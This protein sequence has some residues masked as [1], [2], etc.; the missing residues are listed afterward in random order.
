MKLNAEKYEPRHQNDASIFC[1]LRNPEM[2]SR[3]WGD[4]KDVVVTEVR[5]NRTFLC[6]SLDFC[7]MCFF[8]AHI[9]SLVR[10]KQNKQLRI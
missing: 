9:V 3:R 1:M 4:L 7:R 2:G 8:A 5:F 10:P 6:E